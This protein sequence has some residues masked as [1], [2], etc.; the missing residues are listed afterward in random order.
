MPASKILIASDD[1]YLLTAYTSLLE[2]EGY[3][4]QAASSEADCLR[5]A[6]EHRPELI[7][8]DSPLYGVDGATMLRRL[9]SDPA[10][11][12]ATLLILNSQSP[13][14]AERP[15]ETLS[16]ADAYLSKPFGADEFVGRVRE[17]LG[18]RREGETE[19]G[20]RQGGPSPDKCARLLHVFNHS[21]ALIAVVGGEGRVFQLVNPTFRHYAGGQ[22]LVGRPARDALDG[23]FWGSFLTKIE[24]VY[25]TGQA[26]AI[27]DWLFLPRGE[28][29]LS[30]I[31]LLDFTFQP[32]HEGDGPVSAVFA[33][34]SDVT[35]S[36]RRAADAE[37][38]AALREGHRTPV[39]SH[40]LRTSLSP[41][42]D[43]TYLLS[44]E[45]PADPDE[46]EQGL[47]VIS[48]SARELDELLRA[49]VDLAD[50]LRE[51]S[52]ARGPSLRFENS[53][54]PID[55][56]IVDVAEGLF[57]LAHQRGI[58]VQLA[59]DTGSRP[60]P[61]IGDN[62]RLKQVF[63]NLLQNAIRFSDEGGRV[64]VYLQ[65]S[66]ESVLVKI[67]DEG[68]GI[69]REAL[70]HIFHA[71]RDTPTRGTRAGLGLAIT[72]E[73][74]KMHGGS[75]SV[76]SEG[77]NHGATFTVELPAM[78]AGADVADRGGSSVETRGLPEE[79]E[80][81]P[82][83]PEYKRISA[84]IDER[85]SEPDTPLVVGDTYT[86]SLRVGMGEVSGELIVSPDAV[87]PPSDIPEGGLETTWLVKSS[88]VELAISE[89]DAD[90]MV[91]KDDSSRS[92]LATFALRIPEHGPSH[93][94]KLLV[95]PRVAE[96]ARLDITIFVR[97]QT[98]YSEEQRVYRQ[99][100]VELNVVE[101]EGG[102]RP[103]AARVSGD[104]IHGPGKYVALAPPHEWQTP[105][106][107]L[108]L[109]VNSDTDAVVFGN[110]GLGTAYGDAVR[111]NGSMGQI[112]TLIK[113]VRLAADEFRAAST[114]EL[115]AIDPQDLC[116]RLQALKGNPDNH[117]ADDLADDAHRRAWEDKVRDSDELR[118]LA[119][120]GYALYRRLFPDTSELRQWLDSL[121]PGWRV[122]IA[123]PGA[124]VSHVPWGLL[125][126]RPVV[127]GEPV[128][129]MSFWGLRLRVD[130][131]VRSLKPRSPAL[132]DFDRTRRV[133]GF[134]WGADA[135]L[136]SE[137]AWQRGE[138]EK[139]V[140]RV[141]VPDA[142]APEPP[143]TQLLSLLKGDAR[144]PT[145]LLYFFCYSAGTEGDPALRFGGKA[146]TLVRMDLDG[147][148]LNDQ[149]LI[150][151]NACDTAGADP[152]VV[153]EL[154]QMFFDRGCRAY[155]GTEIKVPVRAA[156]MF[157]KIFYS[158][159]YREVDA[160]PMTAGEAVYQTRRFLWREYRNLA[161]LFYTYINYPDLYMAEDAE[162][163]RR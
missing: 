68:R 38:R 130:Y 26:R 3:E 23:N 159:F 119:S 144:L 98:Q 8:I 94:R 30:E 36:V 125:Y 43:W 91:K 95:T 114:T 62:L 128:D 41:I 160:Q 42:I 122:Y 92:Y 63:H 90:M 11:P 133:Y 148:Q 9:R 117:E 21:P 115:N 84:S 143:K 86:L 108:N 12:A 132:G 137:A 19:G 78:P 124:W 60:M 32:I 55:S 24:E 17:L 40:E 129:P 89:G 120:E 102:G 69:T 76:S 44:G 150:F 110:T 113:N 104:F 161:G 48:K 37:W 153:N 52:V 27:R 39:S 73:L 106:G 121:T 105:P 127:G 100:R 139:R 83:A 75:I 131:M 154:T 13:S 56:V 93:V 49:R 77:E 146:D 74:V 5:L 112:S 101:G 99:F 25:A 70:P 163:D 1:R 109:I 57:P 157:A 59:V 4:V 28:R 151:V 7:I 15:G 14:L 67:T 116:R 31:R 149:P 152:F 156:S 134:Y 138:L 96:G 20:L 65:G 16:G 47:R 141:F 72:H 66:G 2:R 51:I 50:E 140:N 35:E 111:W 80:A 18:A 53:P 142:N 54:V 45:R 88:N 22:D 162:I 10:A 46:I 61:V 79:G 71:F 135:E 29:K 103:T 82:P 107:Q 126:A 118:K 145:P 147:P 58:D 158:Y 64:R 81:R 33:H 87:V 155:L 97:L 6:A 34:G 136:A 85:A 123:W